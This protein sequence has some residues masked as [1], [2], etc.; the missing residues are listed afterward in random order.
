[1]EGSL[2][3][4]LVRGSDGAVLSEGRVVHVYTFRDGLIARMDVEES[5]TDLAW[6]P[7]RLVASGG[8]RV[9]HWVPTRARFR[10]HAIAKARGFKPPSSP[11]LKVAQVMRMQRAHP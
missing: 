3:N 5:A 11:D 2:W 6:I 8:S 10:D 7:P 1:M 9:A 4:Q